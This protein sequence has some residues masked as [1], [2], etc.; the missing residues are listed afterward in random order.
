MTDFVTP[1]TWSIGELITK[2][3][4]DTHVRDQFNAL[5]PYTAGGQIALSSLSNRLTIL[6]A[7]SNSNKKIVSN[8]T[9]FVLQDDT[10][11]MSALLNT[12]IALNTGNNIARFRIPLGLDGYRISYVA[13]SRQSGTGVLTVRLQNVRT[14]NYVLSTNMTIDSGET[15]T[16]TAATPAV[17]NTA[18]DDVAD[19]DQIAIDVV[20]AGTSTL[21]TIVQMGLV[22][23]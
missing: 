11:Y 13:M 15:D 22:R 18:N 12:D 20:D 5:W 14:G 4:M 21:M 17:I 19:G 16:K 3:M 10:R 1:R 8:G 2:A 6:D 7:A 9:T 23:Y